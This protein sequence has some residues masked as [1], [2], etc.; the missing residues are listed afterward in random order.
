MKKVLLLAMVLLL[1]T[2]MKSQICGGPALLNEDFSNGIPGSWTNLDID[3][4]PPYPTMVLK[5]FTGQFQSFVHLGEKCVATT[6]QFSQTGVADDYLITPAI[7]LGSGT[8]CLSWRASAQFSF[9]TETYQVMISTT[10]PTVGALSP[11]L[12]VSSE[13]PVWTEHSL[14]LTA[15]AGQTVYLAFHHNSYQGYAFY[16]TDIRVSSPVN[17]DASVTALNLKEIITPGTHGI[18]GTLLNAGTVPLTSLTLNWSLNN[19]P[20]NSTAFTSLNVA[21]G[22]YYAFTHSIPWQPSAN[23]TYL[24]KI[25]SSN[26]NGSSDQYPGNDT[27]TRIIFVN[28]FQRKILIEEFTQAG[29]IPCAIINPYF[30]SVLLP[31]QLNGKISVIKYHVSW[32]GV[33]PMFNFNPGDPTQRVI[34]Y[35]IA[36]V[37][38]VALDG[39]LLPN[40]CNQ[41]TGYPGCLDQT[42]IDNAFIL[43]TIFDLDLTE[44]NTGN[45]LIVSVNITAKSDI[46]LT[47]LRLYTA[48]VE[49]SIQYNGSN[50]ETEF[51]QVLRYLYPDSLGQPLSTML[52]NQTV[53][54]SYAVPIDIS[55]ISNQVHAVAFIRSDLDGRIYQSDDANTVT[56][57]IQELSTW[58]LYVYPNPTSTSLY[59]KFSGEH[60]AN[61]NW[62][63]SNTMAQVVLSGVNRN[64][65]RIE[66]GALP[67]GIYLIKLWEGGKQYTQ[68]FVK[69]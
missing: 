67:P 51:S 4:I 29:C 13:P 61:L 28:T 54:F 57:G 49:D 47:N 64:S 26:V 34:D 36:S 58:N 38:N 65:S 22:S 15:Y 41:L 52:N 1:G 60:E 20:P 31:N 19:G 44:N 59:F 69:K 37:P 5:G 53:N 14:D 8:Q 68:R 21:P 42:D 11:I 46:P 16:L 43:P 7:V 6:S 56:P 45:T 10:T 3:G 55:F 33:D 30:D 39:E 32:P 48:I 12:S 40:D 23:G 17:R 2:G 24:M 35:G 62:E 63:I 25:W 50:G 27:L 18:N 9:Y 66:I